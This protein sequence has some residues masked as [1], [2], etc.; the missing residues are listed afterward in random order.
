M[1]V[2]HISKASYP[3]Q[4]EDRVAFHYLPNAREG[5]HFSIST[6]RPAKGSVSE[7]RKALIC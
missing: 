4:P 6:P 1:N 3:S 5:D 2:A 7:C